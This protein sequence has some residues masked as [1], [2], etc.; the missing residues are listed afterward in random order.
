MNN[1]TSYM[2]QSTLITRQ[3]NHG[4][5]SRTALVYP[6]HQHAKHS[7]DPMLESVTLLLNNN[8][9]LKDGY[10]TLLSYVRRRKHCRLRLRESIGLSSGRRRM[11][12]SLKRF[13]AIQTLE[14][15]H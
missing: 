14:K 5:Q 10:L 2:Y 9:L 3:H 13:S 1:N 11:T 15:L 6:F 4:Q 8:M 12:T 7:L